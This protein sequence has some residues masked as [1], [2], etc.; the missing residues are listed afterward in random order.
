LNST[1]I[2]IWPALVLKRGSNTK[3]E[4]AKMLISATAIRTVTI[5]DEPIEGQSSLWTYK[6]RGVRELTSLS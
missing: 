1:A 3:T 6:A 4:K 5:L 2:A